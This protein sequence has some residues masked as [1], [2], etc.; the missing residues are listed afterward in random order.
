MGDPMVLNATTD[1]SDEQMAELCRIV[2]DY[3]VES[4]V[5][6]G[7]E[8]SPETSIRRSQV[9]GLDMEKYPWVYRNVQEIATATNQ[10][11]MFNLIGRMEKI[12]LAIYDESD[13]GFY[14]WHLDWGPGAQYRKISISIPLNDPEEYDGG[15]LEFNYTGDPVP[16]LQKKGLAIVFPSFLMHRVTPVTRGR[17]YS[18]VAWVL[19]RG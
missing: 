6:A 1:F 10:K 7:S 14:R 12:Q 13:Q 15:A 3:N 2:D 9:H 8:L 16:V 19:G 5:S 4:V 18:L 17:R 11:Y